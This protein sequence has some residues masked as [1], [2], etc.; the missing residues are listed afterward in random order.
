MAAISAHN[1]FKCIFLNENDS[2]P[3]RIDCTEICFQETS[4]QY[5]SIGSGNG[6]KPNRRQAITWTNA[7]PVHWHIYAALGGDNTF[8]IVSVNWYFPGAAVIL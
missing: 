8:F 6:L 1:N 4:W 2:I 5:A 7:D 3:I